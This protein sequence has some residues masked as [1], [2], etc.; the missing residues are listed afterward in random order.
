MKAKVLYIILIV[1]FSG[2]SEDF[3]DRPPNARITGGIFP[4]NQEDAINALNAA[5]SSLRTWQYNC[6]GFPILDILSD[7]G[8]KGSN[9]GDAANL[10]LY[11][12]FQH[13]ATDQNP[14][15]W[16]ATLYQAIRKAN[17]VIES[18]AELDNID[19]ELQARIIAEARFLRGY[20]YSIL[21]RAFG[22]VVVVTSSAV[23][24]NDKKGRSPKE[25]V[26]DDLIFPDLEHAA[27]VLPLKSEYPSEDLGRATKGA[28]QALLARMYL[29]VG[30]FINAEKNAME[31]INSGEYA[32]EETFSDAFSV[33]I[34]F[35]QESV[36]EVGANGR[37]R[38]SE[39]GHQ[40]AQTQGVRGNPSKGWGF[41]RPSYETILS[42][43][44]DP[45]LDAS[46]IF[47]GEELDGI[48]I[49]G[50]DATP[51]TTYDLEGNIVEIECYNQKVW[52]PY[53]AE[54]VSYDVNR[55][56]VRYADVLLMAGEALN[57]NG[58]SAQALPY[59]NEVRA[60]ARG[61]D[62]ALLP[63]ITTTNQSE[64]RDIIFTERNRELAF[65][66]LRFWDLVRTG[67]AVE[68]LG[69]LGFVEGTHELFPI[70]L[71]E[72][73]NSNGAIQQNFGY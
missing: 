18:V 36:F 65:E 72:I 11:D 66:G 31:V 10:N 57:E 22:D 9:P 55:R 8:L 47:L 41:N 5:Y 46:V 34:V 14:R 56:I 49:I 35:G 13:D 2:C 63:D 60:R 20:H 28:A 19:P 54:N 50:D 42:F 26:W 32:L 29:F 30:D 61:E 70:P 59:L 3:L 68:I 48:P 25:E 12:N 53:E 52:T 6:G 24:Y 40:W 7:E 23:D 37:N 38:A 15:R 58:K 69:P 17:L 43:G 67:R 16:W 51:D 4:A 45:R 73:D 44:D 71:T 21:V 33:D 1:I 62:D 64:L 27:D 39:G